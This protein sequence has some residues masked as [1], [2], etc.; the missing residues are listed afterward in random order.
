MSFSNYLE[1]KVLDHVLGE[2]LRNFTSPATLFISLHSADP[3]ET[4]ASELSGNGYA[5]VAAN[6]AASSAGSSS[7]S[8]DVVFGPAVTADWLQATHFGVYDASTAGNFLMG[9]ALTTPQTIV[10]GAT[11]T[12]STG[13]LTA[14]L[15]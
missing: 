13:N 2:G 4:G 14:S 6:F 9:G 8:A 12:F 10:V 15:D 7:I 1:D 11:G 3:G 5:R